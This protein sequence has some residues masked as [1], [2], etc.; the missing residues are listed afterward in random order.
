MKINE[1]M[2]DMAV[3]VEQQGNNLD[4]ISQEL[5]TTNK[6]MTDTVKY[7]EQASELQKKS[8]KKYICLVIIIIILV[9]ATVGVI[10]ILN[11]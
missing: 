11:S 10:V 4:V 9:A 5:M 7:T 8:K 3:E 1:I 2:N 6:N